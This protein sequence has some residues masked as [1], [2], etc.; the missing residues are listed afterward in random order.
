ME[1]GLS[2]IQKMHERIDALIVK[3]ESQQN[4]IERLRSDVIMLKGESDAKTNE[5]NSL[6]E[7][8]HHRDRELESIYYR[9]NE[10]TNS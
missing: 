6:L 10:L 1:E 7:Q 5:M 8:L 2:L 4:E 3:I 9:L